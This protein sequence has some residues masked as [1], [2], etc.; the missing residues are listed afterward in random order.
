MRHS[1]QHQVYHIFIWVFV[2][3]LLGSIHWRVICCCWCPCTVYGLT[4]PGCFSILRLAGLFLP[5]TW[6]IN[7]KWMLL[8]QSALLGVET[9]DYFSLLSSPSWLAYLI[10]IVILFLLVSPV[11]AI[12]LNGKYASWFH[13]PVIYDFIMN[14]YQCQVVENCYCLGATLLVYQFHW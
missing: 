3:L 11:D 9:C 5:A 13:Q 4:R 7:L 10:L 2:L 6:D 14:L 12:L 1:W 8:N